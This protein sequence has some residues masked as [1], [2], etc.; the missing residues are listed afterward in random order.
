[1]KFIQVHHIQHWQ[2]GWIF[3]DTWNVFGRFGRFVAIC[4]SVYNCQ[5]VD[6]TPLRKAWERNGSVAELVGLLLGLRCFVHETRHVFPVFS[7]A[8]HWWPC[9]LAAA[10]GAWARRLRGS[11]WNLLV[12]IDPELPGWWVW[13]SDG[14]RML[15]FDM[16]KTSRDAG[17]GGV[18]STGN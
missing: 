9:A 17:C 15:A 2:I 7:W 8:R 16:P 13:S 10:W 11:Y 4:F 6:V 1:M 3:S 14:W 18:S 12:F 5:V